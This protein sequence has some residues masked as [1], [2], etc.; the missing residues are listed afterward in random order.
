MVHLVEQILE[1]IDRSQVSHSRDDNVSHT[2]G[3][4]TT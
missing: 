2:I 3:D 1:V 4:F